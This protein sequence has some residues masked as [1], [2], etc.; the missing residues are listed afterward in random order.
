MQKYISKYRVYYCPE[1][2]GQ[3]YCG[4]FDSYDDAKA[5]ADKEPDGTHESMWGSMRAAGGMSRYNAPDPSG[6]EEEGEY[7]Y[8]TGEN[9]EYYVVEARYPRAIT[10]YVRML[11]DGVECDEVYWGADKPS[12]AQIEKDCRDCVMDWDCERDPHGDSFDIQ[13]ELYEVDEENE[14]EECIDKGS[15][16]VLTPADD[17]SLIAQAARDAG[18]T[19]YCGDDPDDHSWEGEGGCDSNPGVWSVGGTSMQYVHVCTECGLRR[20]EI[21]HGWQRNEGEP[22]SVEYE[23]NNKENDNG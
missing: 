9:G 15:E 4:E 16:Q 5:L 17:A 3:T 12:D 2:S 18:R 10:Y 19:A 21:N 23:F 6:I 20:T 8:C 13:W 14:E 7:E 1:G 22:D 11:S